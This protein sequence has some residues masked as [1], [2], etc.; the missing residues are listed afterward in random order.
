M[1]FRKH[2]ELNVCVLLRFI[3]AK[4]LFWGG[5]PFRKW[6]D[7]EDGASI[8]GISALM[9]E[10]PEPP[11]QREDAN[12]MLN[13][14]GPGSHTSQ[15]PELWAVGFYWSP[16]AHAMLSSSS[17]LDGLGQEIVTGCIILMTDTLAWMFL[18]IS[19]TSEINLG[20]VFAIPRQHCL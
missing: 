10:S 8:N 16:S 12:Q 19:L 15:P 13:P 20:R 18:W 3:A 5:G 4:V 14:P 17:V 2:R 9:K 7:H 6:W 11:P 1:P